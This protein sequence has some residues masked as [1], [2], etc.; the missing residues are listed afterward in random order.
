A[1]LQA[2]A[3]VFATANGNIYATA[4]AQARGPAMA[5]AAANNATATATAY[6]NLLNL[7]ISGTAALDDGL[8]DNSGNHKWDETTGT[9]KGACVFISQVYHAIEPQLGYYQLCMARATNFSNFAYQ[10]HM[11]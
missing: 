4:T 3:N 5:T 9:T 10:V 2:T 8:T 11:V 6:D 7:A 1:K